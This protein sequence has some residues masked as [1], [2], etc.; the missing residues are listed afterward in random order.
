MHFFNLY[1]FSRMRRRSRLEI[2]LPPVEPDACLA[3][4]A[5]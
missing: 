3:S 4:G 5:R 2:N 1:V